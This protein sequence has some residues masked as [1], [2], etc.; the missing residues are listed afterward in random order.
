MG[1]FEPLTCACSRREQPS[2]LLPSVPRGGFSSHAKL[3]YFSY[4]SPLSESARL[5]FALRAEHGGLVDL[6]LLYNEVPGRRVAHC[7]K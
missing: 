6:E 2:L 7:K 1:V 4:W 3:W 5:L